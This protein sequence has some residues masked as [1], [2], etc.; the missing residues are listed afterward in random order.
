[1]ET[2]HLNKKSKFIVI[3]SAFVALQACGFSLFNG[4]VISMNLQ[5]VSERRWQ[6]AREEGNEEDERRC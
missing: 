4:K 3:I 5:A 1:M 6:H 2:L